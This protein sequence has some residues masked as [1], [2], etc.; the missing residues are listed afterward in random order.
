MSNIRKAI[1]LS[2]LAVVLVTPALAGEAL[3]RTKVGELAMTPMSTDH[4]YAAGQTLQYVVEHPGATYIKVHFSTFDLAPGDRLVVSSADGT[5]RYAFEGKGYKNRGADFWVNSVLGDRAILTL[6]S[7][8]SG[9]YGFDIDY[10]AYGIAPLFPPPDEDELESVCGTNQ[11]TDVACNTASYPTEVERAKRAVVVLYNGIHNCT[12]VK[13]GCPNQFLTNEHCVTSQFEV[14]ITEVR[15]DY[16]RSACN[17]GTTTFSES[18]LGDLF[19]Q[20][21][22]TLDYCLFTTLGASDN[23]LAAELDD[24]LPPVGERLYISG[25]PQGGPK[26]L[27]IE[28]DQSP[29]GLCRADFSPISGRGVGSDVGYF[30]DTTGGSSGSPVWSGVT[31]KVIALHHF[32]GCPNSGG[33]MDLILPQISSLLSDCTANICGDGNAAGTEECD[34]ADLNGAA[35][36]DIGC[37]SGT[38]TCLTDCTLDYSA[39][40]G[41]PACDN[42]GT[43]EAGEDCTSCANDCPTFTGGAVC[44]N[45]VCETAAGEDCLSCS[46]DC[47]GK[48]NGRESRRYCCGDGDGQSP[49]GCNDSRC[50]SDINTCT[51]TP[52]GS[53]C[54]GDLLCEGSETSANC[55]ID[56]GADPC[57][58]LICEPGFGEDSCTCPGDCGPPAGSE[59]SCGDGTDNDCDGNVDC[60]DSDCN[61]VPPCPD[62]VTAGGSCSAN[63]DCCSTRCKGNGTCK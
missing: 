15:F 19:V 3:G 48:Q 22:F 44:G 59:T 41:C 24:R 32:G 29:T 2:I 61:G 20:D 38:P 13:V 5:E 56:C 49:V 57:G 42:D 26:K 6:H 7:A 63:S 36:S 40:G 34:G 43:C 21:D 60:N 58:N 14:D 35:C 51:S 52:T 50:T 47:N 62:C 10:Y 37:T 39:C 16:Q 12:G 17:G 45:N 9:G 11:W 33:R 54:C 27:S 31:H 4:P 46:S 1:G 23:Y 53:A 18:Y 30:C 28:D 55:E 25:H 8:G